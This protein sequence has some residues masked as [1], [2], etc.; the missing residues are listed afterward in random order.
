MSAAVTRGAWPLRSVPK[1]FAS[2]KRSGFSLLPH[3]SLLGCEAWSVVFAG[4]PVPRLVP[5][6]GLMVLLLRRR[7]PFDIYLFVDWWASVPSKETHAWLILTSVSSI[8]SNAG[9]IWATAAEEG[10]Q[11]MPPNFTC[12][13]LLDWASRPADPRKAWSN[14]FSQRALGL[15]APCLLVRL[16]RLLPPRSWCATGACCVSL[17]MDEVSFLCTVPS[18]HV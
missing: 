7:S 13:A 16:L 11:W 9:V 12:N 10:W 6:R 8:S 1:P 3:T 15:H 17:V 4:L 5:L 14:V 18:W 2:D